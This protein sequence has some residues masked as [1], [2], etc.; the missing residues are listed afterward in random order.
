[1]I[2]VCESFCA[3]TADFHLR[4]LP[5]RDQNESAT[6]PDVGPLQGNAEHELLAAS[7]RRSKV[8]QYK[9][10]FLQRRVSNVPMYDTR[11]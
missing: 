9:Q 3:A 7:C 5:D 6:V 11:V 1:M 8:K 10:V 2:T 4:A